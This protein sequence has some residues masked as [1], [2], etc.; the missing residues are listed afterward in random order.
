MEQN[1]YVYCDIQQGMYG[2]TQTG[3]IAN[4]LLTQHLAH[5]D[6]GSISGGP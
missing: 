6:Y 5:Q 4:D 3:I 2:L 1:G